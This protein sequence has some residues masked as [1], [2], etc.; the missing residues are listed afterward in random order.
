MTNL[1]DPPFVQD[2]ATCWRVQRHSIKEREREPHFSPADAESVHDKK[3]MN[4][5]FSVPVRTKPPSISIHCS[6]RGSNSACSS[7]RHTTMEWFEEFSILT[8]KG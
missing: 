6:V 5:E 4:F 2:M 1:S 8:G 3:E 7:N